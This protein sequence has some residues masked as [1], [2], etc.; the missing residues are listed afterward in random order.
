MDIQR[1]QTLAGVI[2]EGRPGRK[3]V[4]DLYHG[5]STAFFD[6]ILKH[7][8]L[9]EVEHSSYGSIGD[10][11]AFESYG[12][13]YLTKSIGTAAGAALDASKKHGGKPMIVTVQYVVGSGGVDEDYLFMSW[14][15]LIY[16]SKTV[17]PELIQTALDFFP[18]KV[19]NDTRTY[20]KL[21]F[22]LAIAI[23]DSMDKGKFD[24]YEHVLPDPQIRFVV[25]KIIESIKSR[26]H[27]IDGNINNVRVTRPIKFKGKT[28]IISM[29][30]IEPVDKHFVHGEII[31]PK[32]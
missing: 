26:P 9:P 21:F 24:M 19:G 30:V 23:R 32:K 1:L 12:G 8:L 7:G 11:P 6:S 10:D 25:K 4:T 20:T 3:K 31:Y 2:S 28:K 22:K 18:F 5:T 17:S 16:D 15:G 13:V 27:D 14:A 29:Q